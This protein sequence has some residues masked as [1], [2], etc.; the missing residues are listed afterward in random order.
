MKR[1]GKP[2]DL[3]GVM[4][5]LAS[6]ESEFITGADIFVDGGWNINGLST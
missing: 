2:Q 1:W 5:F 6:D 4:H 3:I